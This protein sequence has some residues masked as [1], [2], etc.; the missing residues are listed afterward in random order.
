MPLSVFLEGA[1]TEYACGGRPK[2]VL[3]VRPD[4]RISHD[5]GSLSRTPT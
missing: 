3:G 2:E 1:G 5:R 4:P